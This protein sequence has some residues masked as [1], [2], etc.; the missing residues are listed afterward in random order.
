MMNDDEFVQRVQQGVRN[1]RKRRVRMAV[2]GA[3]VLS[4]SLAAPLLLRERDESIVATV[5]DDE[6][7]FS[8]DAID[9][10]D[11]AQLE[12]AL[13]RFDARLAKL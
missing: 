10:L 2:A 9:D 4:V 11:D 7:D 5:E 8:D 13:R 12:R 1:T 6:I 3:S